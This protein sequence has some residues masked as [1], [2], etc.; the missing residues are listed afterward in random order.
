MKSI[1]L[2][3]YS[4][5]F[6]C[7]TTTHVLS[8]D[9]KS[10]EF[11]TNRANEIVRNPFGAKELKAINKV[12]HYIDFHGI[13]S[14]IDMFLERRYSLGYG[15]SWHCDNGR[16][17]ECN[18]RIIG[19]MTSV[20]SMASLYPTTAH[21]HLGFAIHTLQDFYSHTNWI[22]LHREKKVS[23]IDTSGKINTDLGVSELSDAIAGR[24]ENTCSEGGDVLSNA[25]LNKLTS[26]Q[27]DSFLYPCAV[28]SGKCR[29][30][31]Y[32]LPKHCT[33]IHKDIEGKL[34]HAAAVEAATQATVQLL[35][36]MF[37]KLQ[38]CSQAD[39]KSLPGF[40]DIELW[41]LS[42]PKPPGDLTAK[43][44]SSST[45]PTDT[46]IASM[47]VSNSIGLTNFI[48]TPMMLDF[49]VCSEGLKEGCDLFRYGKVDEAFKAFSKAGDFGASNN[50]GVFH[51][52]GLGRKQD[53]AK[54]I[55]EYRK[56]AKNGVP[57]AKYNLGVAL[58]IKTVIVDDK[59]IPT[60]I[61][62]AGS[63]KEAS[64]WLW[65]AARSDLEM[66][67]LSLQRLKMLEQETI[68]QPLP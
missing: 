45:K 46:D 65:A 5:A 55:I 14:I 62:N 47:N 54:A 50:L 35:K 39:Q 33:G 12:S 9:E 15:A 60:V 63:L 53:V 66:A 51:E 44:V 11:I 64:G 7:A 31:S 3:I 29:H 34:G 32:H 28:T 25:G 56:A 59:G 48:G 38:P 37:K 8:F 42:P 52:A 22:E 58:A 4:V 41:C 2:L 19:T 57:M 21:E 67:K 17:N 68:V 18:E 24:D 36:Q 26:G 30:G 49:F 10:H 61:L 20:T 27:Y 13:G 16:L 23:A 43:E 1:L 40:M 6:F